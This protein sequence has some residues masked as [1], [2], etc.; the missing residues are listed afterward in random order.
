MFDAMFA[1]WLF[2]T[3]HVQ[4][5][6]D[7]E[8]DRASGRRTLPIVLSPAGLVRLRQLTFLILTGM[9][10]SFVWLGIKL[11]GDAYTR[12]VGLLALVQFLGGLATAVYFMQATT[13]ARGQ[14]TYEIFHIPTALFIIPYLSLVN[15]VPLEQNIGARV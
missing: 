7:I 3:I 10:L 4:G 6:H 2:G 5:F 12:W 9:A 11:C 8:G 15:N 14:N 13:T 1:L